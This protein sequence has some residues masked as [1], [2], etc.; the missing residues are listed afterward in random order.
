MIY[1]SDLTIFQSGR[2]VKLITHLY[3][4]PTLGMR[5]IYIYIYIYLSTLP[6]PLLCDTKELSFIVYK[7]IRQSHCSGSW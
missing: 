7:F 3:L 1:C 5:D 4:A 6:H 2:Y